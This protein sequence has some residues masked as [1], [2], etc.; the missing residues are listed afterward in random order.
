MSIP[1]PAD[2]LFWFFAAAA[3]GGAAYAVTSAHLIR[4]I[5]AFGAFLTAVAGEYYLLAAEFVA[6]V[7]I[8]VYVG[9]VLVLM[10]FALMLSTPGE[11]QPS[12]LGRWSPAVGVTAVGVG[13]AIMIAAWHTPLPVVKEPAAGRLDHLGQALLGDHV[14]VF[15][16]VGVLLF[17][18]VVTALVA[19]RGERR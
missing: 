18:A 2:I 13:A 15:E 19:V 10:L 1:A 4:S 16:L 17:A 11:S 12:S 9:G 3:V 5:L 6:L 14:V 7:Q 8:F